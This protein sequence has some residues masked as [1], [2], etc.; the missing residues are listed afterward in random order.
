[1]KTK[2]TVWAIVVVFIAA[3][4][5]VTYAVFYQ[6]AI[7]RHTWEL[8]SAIKIGEPFP[9]V[10][11]KAGLDVSDDKYF[12]YS[13]EVELICTA[14]DG[15]L[16]LTDKTNDK[17]YEGTYRVGSNF[18]FR[19]EDYECVIDGKECTANI[20][21]KYISNASYM[22]ANLWNG[23]TLTVNIDGYTLTFAKK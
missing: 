5:A 7:E 14:E 3:L 23:D 21:Y 19:G 1:M 10:A 17:V 9:A 8:I 20:S 15:K 13:K 6:P 2:K 11:H 18:R 22:Y 12:M 16:T 4:T